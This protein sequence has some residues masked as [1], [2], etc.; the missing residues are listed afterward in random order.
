MLYFVIIQFPVTERNR[1]LASQEE[2][3]QMREQ[4]LENANLLASPALSQSGSKFFF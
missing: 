3:S 2:I 1:S 4:L